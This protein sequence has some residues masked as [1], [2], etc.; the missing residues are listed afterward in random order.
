MLPVADKV[1]SVLT[2]KLAKA[3]LDSATLMPLT[4]VSVVT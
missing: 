1:L 3:F 4:K 2:G